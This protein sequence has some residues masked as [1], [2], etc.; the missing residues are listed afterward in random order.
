MAQDGSSA[1]TVGTMYITRDIGNRATILAVSRVTPLQ[2][3]EVKIGYVTKDPVYQKV[4]LYISDKTFDLSFGKRVTGLTQLRLEPDSIHEGFI[5]F[6]PYG[7]SFE[8]TPKND[9]FHVVC[10]DVLWDTHV[11]KCTE[12][13][14]EQVFLFGIRKEFHIT[15]AAMMTD[16]YKTGDAVVMS[17]IVVHGDEAPVHLVCFAWTCMVTKSAITLR[18]YQLPSGR[19]QILVL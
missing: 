7:I 14:D 11:G 13:S 4:C 6:L 9:T 16:H 1:K 12:H 2:C 5:I 3:F 18:I 19:D 17:V 10:Q 8:I 15:F